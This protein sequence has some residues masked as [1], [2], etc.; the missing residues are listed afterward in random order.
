MKLELQE[1]SDEER[2]EAL[3]DLFEEPKIFWGRE[4]N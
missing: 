3:T 1:V 4:F 2:E